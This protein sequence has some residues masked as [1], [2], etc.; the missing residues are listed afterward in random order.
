MKKHIRLFLF[1]VTFLAVSGTNAQVNVRDSCIST[2]IMYGVYGFHFLSGD[3]SDM[4]GNSSTIGAGLGYKLDNNIYFGLEYSYLF[5]GKVKNGDEIL[6]DIL[7]ED[8]Q[9]IGQGGEYAIFQYMQR[10]HIIWAQVGKIFPV[11]SP[12]PNSGI[13]IKLGAGFTQHRMDVSVQENTAP[14]VK[15]DYKY[16]YD[17]LTRGFGLNQFIGYQYLGD[18]RIWN[19]YGGLDFSQAW[20]KNVRDLNFD[21]RQ[22]DNS[23][24][25]DLYF[26]FKIGWIIPFY[27][28]A[29]SGYYY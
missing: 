23:Q 27:R 1:I 29:P 26:G 21:T 28:Q 11:F 8:G 13:L 10:G 9:L 6:Q 22:K 12:N 17:R 20:T 3:I 19:F 4:Y 2:P 24:H 15:D 14:Q 16:G 25:L 7:T 5:G 18:S